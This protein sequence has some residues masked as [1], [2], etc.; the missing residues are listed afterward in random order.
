[1]MKEKEVILMYVKLAFRNVKKSYREFM[2]YFVTL[3]FS[4]CLFYTFNSFQA[5]EDMMVLREAQS[6]VMMTIAIFMVILSFLIVIVLAGLILYANRFLIK[7]RK[8]EFGLYL[9]MG[10]KEQEI[11][12]ILVYETFLIG[13][14]SLICG[15]VLG[16]AL[17]QALGVVTANMMA[18]EVSFQFVFSSMAMIMTILAFGLI[19]LITMFAN[20][21]ML[22]K[23]KLIELLGADHKH[24]KQQLHSFFVSI[25]LFLLSILLLGF[26]YKMATVSIV[27]FGTYFFVILF[28]GALGTILFF[29]SLTGFLLRFISKS[30]RLYYRSLHMFVLRQIHSRINTSY[31]SMAVVCLMLLLS[32]GA[33]AT[34]WNLNLGVSSV[35][36]VIA[37]YDASYTQVLDGNEA[38]IPPF[39]EAKV[40]QLLHLTIYESDVQSIDLYEQIDDSVSMKEAFHYKNNLPAISYSDYLAFC[41]QKG[42]APQV[43]GED[44]YMFYA[45]M[46]DMMKL[47]DELQ[48][49][50]MDLSVFG[51]TLQPSDHA[52]YLQPYTDVFT[53][54]MGIVLPDQLVQ[55][56]ARQMKQVMNFDVAADVEVEQFQK[57]LDTQLQGRSD[58]QTVTRLEAYDNTIS[59]GMLF[60]YIGL[61]LGVVF[62]MASAVILALQQLT[63]ADHS[64]KQYAILKKIG[65]DQKMIKHSVYEQIGIY[66]LLPLLLAS[67][68]AY[69]GIQAVAVSF[70]AVC[71]TGSLTGASLLSGGCIVLIYGIYFFCTVQGYQRI[72]HQGS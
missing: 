25:L 7:R 11:A 60:T 70:A 34:G 6:T 30:K 10:M 28:T 59:F 66:F 45:P 42:I 31:L 1:M 36:E 9:L 21:R 43:M 50:G 71:G 69:F 35:Y 19:F 23:Q 29:F 39:D 22:R 41:D 57:E 61:Y 65:V 48:V 24:E 47:V 8:K 37:P 20:I 13:L 67:I 14:C 15:L 18:V 44:E 62:L 53:S 72:L 64:I 17:S 32:I 3:M 52:L 63:E 12:K 54:S 56:H 2:I 58:W 51:T 5:Q 55:T 4:V 27:S 16:I 40:K 68:H 49:Q 46:E 26:T 38:F 33:L